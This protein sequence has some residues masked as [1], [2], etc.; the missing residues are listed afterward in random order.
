MEHRR[1]TSGRVPQ[2]FRRQTREK[3]PVKLTSTSGPAKDTTLSKSTTSSVPSES[4]SSYAYGVPGGGKLMWAK[5]EDLS[6]LETR[7]KPSGAT[8]SNPVANKK[9][10]KTAGTGSAAK[11]SDDLSQGIQMQQAGL[12]VC[13]FIEEHFSSH[14]CD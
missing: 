1:N 3:P 7:Y 10:K 6:K 9:N 8:E 5:P 14:K 2:G 13:F 12:P 4:P 11:K